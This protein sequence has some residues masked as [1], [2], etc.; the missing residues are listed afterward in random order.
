MKKIIFLISLLIF[1]IN[2][3][4][5]TD[6]VKRANDITAL[7]TKALSLNKEDQSKVYQIQLERFQE[8]TLIR[9]KYEDNPEI[10]R[11]ELRKVYNKLYGKLKGNLGEKKMFLW[12]K[13]KR[14][15]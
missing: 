6:D 5:Q 14:N 13:Y 10:K 15:N 4:A 12:Q 8:V 2:I 9:D 7:M 11:A 1:S 3:N